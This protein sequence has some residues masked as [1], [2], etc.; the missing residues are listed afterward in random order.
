L[1]ADKAAIKS[2]TANPTTET[3]PNKISN[4]TNTNNP[5]NPSETISSTNTI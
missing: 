1:L 2:A 3:Y 4:T 5:A